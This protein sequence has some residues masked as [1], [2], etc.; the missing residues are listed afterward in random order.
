MYSQSKEVGLIQS[1]RLDPHAFYYLGN[2]RMVGIV[3]SRV[4]TESLGINIFLP[5]SEHGNAGIE[6]KPVIVKLV[7][8]SVFIHICVVNYKRAFAFS[9]VAELAASFQLRNSPDYGHIWTSF[10]IA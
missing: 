2:N 3:F 9:T 6:K 7:F 4:K 8:I 1:T 5:V 10:F